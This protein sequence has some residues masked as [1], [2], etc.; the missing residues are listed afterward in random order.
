MARY[1]YEWKPTQHGNRLFRRP[2]A[3]PAKPVKAAAPPEPEPSDYDALK[4]DDLIEA[5]EKR[6]LD[7]S[8]TKADIIDR[9]E[10]DD[11]D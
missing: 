8:G 5:A 3:A 1:I 2:T 9:L 4:K 7:S 11:G 6:E 10:A